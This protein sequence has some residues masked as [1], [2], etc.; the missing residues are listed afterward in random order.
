MF[1][2]WTLVPRYDMLKHSCF[3]SNRLSW[4]FQRTQRLY[5]DRY[6]TGSENDDC[7]DD[8]QFQVYRSLCH[9]ICAA[10]FGV[11]IGGFSSWPPDG[12]TS[13]SRSLKDTKNAFPAA[14][15][16]MSSSLTSAG[17]SLYIRKLFVT[18]W[19]E[20]LAVRFAPPHLLLPGKPI[21]NRDNQ[22]LQN[23]RFIFKIVVCGLIRL[24]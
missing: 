3:V 11:I 4:R 7:D 9:Q 19:A 15:N 10:D 18:G 8:D 1:E 12:T 21:R 14:I 5:A 16:E 6:N 23:V 17:Q 24:Q 2:R 22:G 13:H 20:I